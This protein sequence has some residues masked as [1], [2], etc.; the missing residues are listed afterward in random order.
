MHRKVGQALGEWGQYMDE[1]YDLK[2]S[3]VASGSAT[4]SR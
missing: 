3:Q 4:D 2:K 1:L